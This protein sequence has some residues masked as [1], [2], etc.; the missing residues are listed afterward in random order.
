MSIK[1]GKNIEVRAA[2][3]LKE[4]KELR[5]KTTAIRQA[6]RAKSNAEIVKT[7]RAFFAG[8]EKDPAV[9]CEKLAEIFVVEKDNLDQVSLSKTSKEK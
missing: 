3:L 8:G 1:S 4:R 9:L 6:V 7:V 5:S 2:R